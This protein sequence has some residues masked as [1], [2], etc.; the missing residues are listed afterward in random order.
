MAFGNTSGETP[1][2][3]PQIEGQRSHLVPPPPSEAHGQ[4]DASS[5]DSWACNPRVL[6]LLS[7]AKEL[8]ESGTLSERQLEHQLIAQLKVRRF[9]PTP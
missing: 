9:Y 8:L 7:R 2:T 5:L 6:L 4:G 3:Q 1:Q